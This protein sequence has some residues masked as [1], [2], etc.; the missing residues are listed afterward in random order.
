[1]S[2]V[3]FQGKSQ[4]VKYAVMN[5]FVSLVMTVISVIALAI[6]YRR[7]AIFFAG[8][9]VTGTAEVLIFHSTMIYEN[10]INIYVGSRDS[11]AHPASY[12]VGKAATA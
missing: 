11:T 5:H 3:C 10:N 9:I 4:W 7:A 6:F 12:P 2:V 8:L 1:M